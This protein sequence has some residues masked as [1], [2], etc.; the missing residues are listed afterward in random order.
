MKTDG[1][2]NL[3]YGPSDPE[4]DSNEG[5]WTMQWQ[6]GG[7]DIGP[8]YRFWIVWQPTGL[9]VVATQLANPNCGGSR[10]YGILGQIKYQ[11]T[12]T[13]FDGGTIYNVNTFGEVTFTPWENDTFYNPDGTVS[14]TSDQ[15]VITS[16]NTPWS[17]PATEDTTATGV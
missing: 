16:L 9:S 8:N 13:P 5:E 17:P 7:I 10:P 15:P 1:N 12:A 2:G 4:P 3:T 6:V 11:T 14:G